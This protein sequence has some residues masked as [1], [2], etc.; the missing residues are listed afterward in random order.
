MIKTI[1]KKRE[2]EREQNKL[3]NN[4][5]EIS[6]FMHQSS[7]LTGYL[8]E[9][10]NLCPSGIEPAGWEL[11]TIEPLSQVLHLVTCLRFHSEIHR[12]NNSHLKCLCF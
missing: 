11:R 8:Q 6:K 4:Q 3:L 7:G 5:I 12:Q 1:K 2:G 10:V 9:S